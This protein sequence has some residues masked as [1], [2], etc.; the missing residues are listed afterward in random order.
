MTAHRRGR[1]DYIDGTWDPEHRD[2]FLVVA[3]NQSRSTDAQRARYTEQNYALAV[4][5]AEETPSNFDLYQ[6]IRAQQRARA[7]VNR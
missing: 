1:R 7:R 2:Y 6:A 3:H 4:E 5:I